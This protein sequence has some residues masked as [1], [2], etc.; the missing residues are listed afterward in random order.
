MSVQFGP[1]GPAGRG[2]VHQ[3][4]QLA[5]HRHGQPLAPW[6]PF[7]QL[8]S[9]ANAS[10]QVHT[11]RR[12]GSSKTSTA[13]TT[14]MVRHPTIP[15]TRHASTPFRSPIVDHAV[16]VDFVFTGSARGRPS[17][18]SRSVQYKVEGGQFANA[19]NVS[20]NWSQF[21]ISCRCR[22]PP[23]ACTTLTIR[24]GHRSARRR[25]LEALRGA[26][27][28]PIVVRRA[29]TRR[30]PARRPRRR[31]RAGR[32]SSRS[33]RDADMRHQLSAR[34]FDPLWM[35]TR[36]WQ[37]GEFQAEDAGTPVQAR[38]RATSAMLSRCHLGEL[39]AEHRPRR[40][41]RLRS[42]AHAARSAGRA[43]R[44]RAGERERRA[45][46][47]ACASRPGCISC[48]CSSSSRCRKSYRPAFIATL[49]AAAP[50]GR[51]PAQSTTRRAR[52]VADDGRARARCAAARC[53]AA[54]AAARRS[55]SLD[56]AL[57]IA[58]ADRAEVQ[59]A[60][61]RWLAWY[62]TLFSEPAT[63]PRRCVEPAAMEYALSVAGAACR[64]SAFD[65]MH[66]LGDRVR[67]RPARLEQLRPQLRSEPGH[68]A[69]SE[70]RVD[71]RDDD[72]RAGD[73]PRRAGAALLGAG[74]CAHRV[75]P[76]AGRPD[77]SRAADDDRIREQLRQRLV[78]RAADA[79]RSARSRASTR[80]SSPTASACARCC[81][82]SA[83]PRL[84]D[85]N[86]SHVAAR[87]HPP[88]RQ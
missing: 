59:Q 9:R 69:R 18:K 53:R 82:R 14:F 30:S 57:N 49:R 16:P 6:G 3:R 79:C 26:A 55:W 88:S 1:G 35:L 31:S 19:V 27:E 62:D 21:D 25:D 64:T 4:P 37:M 85:A 20:G 38:V 8:T 51:V 70:L 40:P 61:T 67:R 71:H 22:L 78:R 86:W 45:H 52:F 74:G 34:V 12:A 50:R 47:D 63:E 87:A 54:H 56:P 29:A 81:A 44:M 41:P 77:R 66:A 24:A 23:A 68:G 17:A 76:D 13:S 84:P 10:L 15:P 2:H 58:A 60:A 43:Q 42:A 73:L 28:P 7:V 5:V 65:E 39:P 36:Q 32:G 72:T 75:R 83:I 33:A 11:R 48:G 80:W 46:A